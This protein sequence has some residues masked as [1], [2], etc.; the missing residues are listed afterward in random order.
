MYMISQR[1]NVN[2]KWI[3]HIKSI[4]DNVGLSYVCNQQ[5]PIHLVELKLTVKQKL[6]DQFIQKWYNL[7]ATSS[8]GNLYG[9]FKMEFKLENYLLKLSPN[10]RALITKLRCCN[11]KI[12]VETGRWVNIPREE[13][14]CHLCHNDI[15]SEY[16]YIF[17]CSFPNVV[18]IRKKHIPSYYTKYPNFQKMIGLL[19]LCNVP[20]LKN[21]SLFIS[22]LRKYLLS[23]DIVFD[24]LLVISIIVFLNY[25]LLFV[26]LLLHMYCV[27]E[28]NKR[29]YTKL[30][31]CDTKFNNE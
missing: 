31:A 21:L 14:I 20:V 24:C 3:N 6:T 10:E 8:R 26:F 16:H 7:I 4:F 18:D 2:F 23:S 11:L 1:E 25:M 13:R 12:P 28:Y 15:G 29:K 17:E 30:V 19:S 22:K 9:Q 5:N 27:R